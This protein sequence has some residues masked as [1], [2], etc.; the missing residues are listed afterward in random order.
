[1]A[2]DYEKDVPKDVRDKVERLLGEELQLFYTAA[3]KPK[4]RGFWFRSTHCRK[5]APPIMAK[6]FE[7]LAK[8]SEEEEKK[9]GGSSSKPSS[10]KPS[11]KPSPAK[12]S[13]AEELAEALAEAV[14]G[15]SAAPEPEEEEVVEIGSLGASPFSEGEITDEIKKLPTVHGTAAGKVAT[16]SIDRMETTRNRICACPRCVKGA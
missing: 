13:A 2:F 4:M 10:A 7:L 11:G 12:K 3:P 6:I 15:R 5:S 14:G 9:G 16:T 1:M 8:L